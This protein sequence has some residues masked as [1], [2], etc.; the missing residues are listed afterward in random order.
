MGIAK[1]ILSGRKLIAGCKEF[2]DGKKFCSVTD[3]LLKDLSFHSKLYGEVAIGFRAECVHEKFRPVMYVKA[4]EGMDQLIAAVKDGML[5]KLIS[6][7]NTK[8]ISTV[9][10][11][12]QLG[13]NL[14][15]DVGAV[16]GLLAGLSEISKPAAPPQNAGIKAALLSLLSFCK[17]T[18]FSAEY[19]GSFYLEREWRCMGNF[20]FQPGDVEAVICPA[21]RMGE[22]HEACLSKGCNAS[23]IAWEMLG[24]V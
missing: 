9:N 3:I 4:G 24:R 8:D 16:I 6:R 21:D 11:Y 15:G 19:L 18:R 10:E 22:L 1:K 23:I 14:G 17:K 7:S 13:Q 20:E 12:M 5:E 2:D